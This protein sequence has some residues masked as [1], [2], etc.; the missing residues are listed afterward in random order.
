MLRYPRSSEDEE[1]VIFWSNC[2]INAFR[3]EQE[4]VMSQ[5][6]YKRGVEDATKPSSRG[7]VILC[8]GVIDVFLKNRLKNLLTKK[9]PKWVIVVKR[10]DI[11]REEFVDSGRLWDSKSAAERYITLSLPESEVLGVFPIEIDVPL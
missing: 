7:E 11:T 10:S 1:Q 4:R 5:A 9:V 8:N 6:D 3:K 2:F